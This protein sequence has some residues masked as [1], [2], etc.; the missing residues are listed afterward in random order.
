MRNFAIIFALVFVLQSCSSISFTNAQPEDTPPIQEFP[1]KIIGRFLNQEDTLVIDRTSF[2]FADGDIVS[3]SGDITPPGAVL[4]KMDEWYVLS[5]QDDTQWWVFPF[6]I[7]KDRI[8]V[9]Y[10]D[11]EEDEQKVIENFKENMEMQKIFK[12]GKLDYY[13]ISP[14]KRQF[15]QLLKKGIFSEKKI[16]RRIK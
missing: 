7:S 9:Y 1:E 12:D 5:I 11:M 15:A 10:S 3:I 6:K 14:S 16:F 8:T 13:L 2:V 4:K